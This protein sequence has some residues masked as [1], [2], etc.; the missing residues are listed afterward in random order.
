MS[1]LALLI[2]KKMCKKFFFKILIISTLILSNSCVTKA[3]WQDAK[4]HENVTKF[5]IGLDPLYVVLIGYDHHYVVVDQTNAL[6]TILS[7][8][9]KRILSVNEDETYI[10]LQKNGNIDGYFAVEGPFD[11]LPAAD[12]SAL[13]NIGIKTYGDKNLSIKIRVKGKRFHLSKLSGSLLTSKTN[14]RIPIHYRNS[15]IIKD[16][17]KIVVTPVT[18]ALDIVII[19]MKP[20]LFTLGFR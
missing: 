17:G 13:R 5:F 8:K 4:Y 7:L 1:Q 9:Q 18:V 19:V 11:L 14:Y 16:F 12:Q 2:L 6:K 10:K 15:N 3:V 20:I